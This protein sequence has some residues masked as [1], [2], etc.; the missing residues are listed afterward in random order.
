MG[1]Y[2]QLTKEAR[3]QI[4]ALMQAG[5]NKT[6][7]ASLLGRHKSTIGREV[8]R[9]HGLRGYRPKQAQQMAD[10]RHE[11]KVQTRIPNETWDWVKQLLI[12]DDWSPEQIS[13]WLVAEKGMSVSHEWIYQFVYQ[14]KR[15]GGDLHSHLRCQKARRKRYGSNDRRGQ[16]KGRISIDDRPEIVNERSRVGDWEVD[17]VIG[18][19]G[20]TVLVTVAERKTRYSVIAL[21]PDKS[22]Q[23]VKE[24]LIVSLR[25]HA[26][27]VHTLTYDNGKEFAYHEAIS[28]E[29]E[30]KGFFAHPYH[31]WE[32]G[33]NENTN[34]LIRQYLPKGMDFHS[35]TQIDIERIMNK[36]NN[37][38]RKCLGFKTPHQV[39]NKAKSA[40]ALTS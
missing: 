27:H 29:L 7:I 26:N 3:Y 5:H 13:G 10:D 17:T 33:L 31:S 8:E 1:S 30:A 16:I 12:D 35:V 11:E 21:S 39:F 40:V 2:T 28:T 19:P 38:P 22:A 25:P 15:Q 18:K 24:A 32:R 23:A 14:D 9:N 20:G 6:E 34:G 4:Y 36:L 37:R